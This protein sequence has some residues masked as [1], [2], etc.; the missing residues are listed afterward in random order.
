[1][2]KPRADSRGRDA[3]RARIGDELNGEP[4]R[5]QCEHAAEREEHVAPPEQIAEHAT[6]GLAEQLAEN[7]TRRVT[8]QDRLQAVGGHDVAEIGQGNRDHPAG[9]RAGG[10]TRQ[11]K[12]RQRGN[13]AANRHQHGGKDAGDGDGAVFAEAVGDRA[14]DELDRTMCDRISG[15]D[16]GR[17][18][19]RGVEVRGDLRQQGI[20]DAHLR[21]AGKARRRQQHDR[22]RRGL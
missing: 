16:D 9:H 15:D 7:V 1:V 11:C 3:A 21:L 8:G 19:D 18:A 4:G 20:G 5:G 22:A 17:G 12:L 6:H 2:T 14:D 13:G 10:E